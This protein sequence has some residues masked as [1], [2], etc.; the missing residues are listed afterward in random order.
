MAASLLG[1]HMHRLLASGRSADREEELRA[2]TG[3]LRKFL[4]VRANDSAAASNW[5]I[6]VARRPLRSS[7]LDFLA[8]G[9][10]LIIVSDAWDRV[11]ICL[12]ARGHPPSRVGCREVSL[13]IRVGRSST[14]GRVGLSS[15]FFSRA[16]KALS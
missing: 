6:E 11:R 14:R 13:R 2:S 5:S 10:R 12:R 1:M 8:R 4:Q 15:V 16:F 9:K 3:A 7:R